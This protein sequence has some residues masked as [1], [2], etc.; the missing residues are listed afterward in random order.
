MVPLHQILILAPSVVI[1]EHWF[2]MNYYAVSRK[3]ETA[4]LLAYKRQKIIF[5]TGSSLVSLKC[6][7]CECNAPYL[8]W[9]TLD[10][11]GSRTYALYSLFKSSQSQAWI[12]KRGVFQTSKPMF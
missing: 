6:P 10:V 9:E 7:Q 12:Q 11:A 2:I 8:K 5:G 1:I 3:R 4:H